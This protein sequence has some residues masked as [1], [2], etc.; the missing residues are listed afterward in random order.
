[1]VRPCTINDIKFF[2]KPAGAASSRV[3]TSTL[4]HSSRKAPTR[5]Q[6]SESAQQCWAQVLVEH[7][8]GVTFGHT[9]ENMKSSHWCD[10]LSHLYLYLSL[11][12]ILDTRS[13]VGLPKMSHPLFSSKAFAHPNRSLSPWFYCPP[14]C[15]SRSVAYPLW[16]RASNLFL[17]LF[18]PALGPQ[19]RL[20]VCVRTSWRLA[21]EHAV[22]RRSFN[23]LL[24]QFSCL[25]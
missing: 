8:T 15:V 21:L 20:F 5:L 13:I 24:I 16:F 9:G 2:L 11:M 3:M 14:S 22:S 1:M 17:P 6:T 18:L 7:H 10:V 23:S 19:R 25:Y 4:G 12:A